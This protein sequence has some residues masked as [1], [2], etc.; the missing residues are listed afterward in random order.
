MKETAGLGH[1]SLAFKILQTEKVHYVQ[2]AVVRRTECQRYLENTQ[3]TC[4]WLYTQGMI[5]KTTKRKT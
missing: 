3:I 1:V 5:P 4:W 2:T